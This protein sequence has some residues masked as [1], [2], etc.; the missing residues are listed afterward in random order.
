MQ[1]NDLNPRYTIKEEIIIEKNLFL[2]VFGHKCD[3]KFRRF[4]LIDKYTDIVSHVFEMIEDSGPYKDDSDYATS[5]QNIMYIRDQ[6]N[7]S[8]QE[9]LSEIYAYFYDLNEVKPQ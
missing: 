3:A 4:S 7:K 8:H 9:Y 6:L 2:D 1:S 5:I